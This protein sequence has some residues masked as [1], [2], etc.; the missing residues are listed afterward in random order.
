MN[1]ISGD[2]MRS[3]IKLVEHSYIESSQD[4]LNEATPFNWRTQLIQAGK[5]LFNPAANRQFMLNQYAN[6][7]YREWKIESQSI[8]QT[9]QAAGSAGVGGSEEPTARDFLTWYAS[10]SAQEG[11]M[12]PASAGAVQTAM[13]QIGVSDLDQPLNDDKLGKLCQQ[14]SVIVQARHAKVTTGILQSATSEEEKQVFDLFAKIDD[15]LLRVGNRLTLNRIGQ[16]IAAE[17]G[18]DKADYT[19]IGRSFR[20]IEVKLKPRLG[21]VAMDALPNPFRFQNKTD[22]LTDR[23]KIQLLQILPTLLLYT[24]RN[25]AAHQ[26]RTPPVPTPAPGSDSSPAAP[27]TTGRVAIDDPD[28]GQ[29]LQDWINRFKAGHSTH[30]LSDEAL[31]RL[32][33]TV[34]TGEKLL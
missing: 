16:I 13:R 26:V 33:F 30:G 6:A 2:S 3:L 32:A 15:K 1:P 11:K 14:I 29:K 22:V 18:V 20:D 28:L 8:K 7:L 5:G 21:S 25:V 9:R 27:G 10:S 23:G 24:I 19:I 4:I 12:L 31:T 34:L 17:L